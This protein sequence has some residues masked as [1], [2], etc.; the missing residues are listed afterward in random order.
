[1]LLT[2]LCVATANPVT[3]QLFVE[4]FSLR[5]GVLWLSSTA[6]SAKSTT[7][8]SSAA[9]SLSAE[10]FASLALLAQDQLFLSVLAFLLVALPQALYR[11]LLL[12]FLDALRMLASL[13]SLFFPTPLLALRV[14]TS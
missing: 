10:S 4:L 9:F 11:D 8:A 3:L 5:L 7:P 13:N 14:A 6:F 2:Q 12:T 1:M